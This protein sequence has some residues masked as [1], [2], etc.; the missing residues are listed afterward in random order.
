ML[1]C[2]RLGLCRVDAQ[3]GDATGEAIMLAAALFYAATKVQR[4]A[5]PA[6]HHRE[7][8]LCLLDWDMPRSLPARY[9]DAIIDADI[10][11]IFTTNKKP[12]EIFPR[13]KRGQKE[14]GRAL[15]SACEANVMLTLRCACAKPQY[16]GLPPSLK[17][18]M[19]ATG[20]KLR[21]PP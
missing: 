7:D 3:E 6:S 18:Y 14:R 10:P 20:E 1:R 21:V 4:R 15:V 2:C 19:H 11:M 9:S 17:R 8:A 12:K 16:R 13:G 5:E